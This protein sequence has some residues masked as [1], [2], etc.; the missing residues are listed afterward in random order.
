MIEQKLQNKVETVVAD[1]LESDALNT[2]PA[3]NPQVEES[4]KQTEMAPEPPQPSI[5]EATS[6]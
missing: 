2:N 3:I 6:L 4:L 5:L 1:A